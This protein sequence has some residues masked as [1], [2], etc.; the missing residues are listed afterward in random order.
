MQNK[1]IAKPSYTKDVVSFLGLG[2]Q[3]YLAARV[4]INSDLLLQG[5]IC[6]STSIEKYFKAILAFRGNKSEGHLKAAHLRAVKNFDPKLYASLNKSFLLFLQKCY[7]LRYLDDLAPN[8]NLLVTARPML[9]ELD[10][11]VFQIENRFEIN[12]GGKRLVIP[13]AA[14][15]KAKEPKLYINNYILNGVDKNAFIANQECL[16]YEMRLDPQK[17]LIEATYKT[18]KMQHDGNFLAEGLKP[19]SL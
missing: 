10:F 8:F 19:K 12:S 6:G 11:T 2:F 1:K 4:L 14:A 13:Y 15:L 17:G 18:E 3:D 16:I 7:K 9:A 5:A